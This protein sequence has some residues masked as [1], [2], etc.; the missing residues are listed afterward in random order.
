LAQALGRS[1]HD[2]GL[3]HPGETEQ[4]LLDLGG[5]DVLASADDDVLLAVG[6]GEV[7]LVVEHPDVPGDVPAAV[8]EGGGGEV[9]LGVALEAVGAAAEELTGFAGPDVLSTLDDQPQLDARERA[10]VGV[11][12]LV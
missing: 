3:G 2:G 10:A 5:A 11:A 6:D 7:A 4:E 12:T 8:D 9:G 1:G